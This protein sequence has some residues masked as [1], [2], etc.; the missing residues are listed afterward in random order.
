MPADDTVT[1]KMIF[2]HVFSLGSPLTF[3]KVAGS[4]FGARLSRN[5]FTYDNTG[6]YES[7]TPCTFLSLVQVGHLCQAV[8]TCSQTDLQSAAYMKF[9]QL[10]A[11]DLCRW[12]CLN[13][14]SRHTNFRDTFPPSSR[15]LMQFAANLRKSPSAVVNCIA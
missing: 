5:C 15:D 11:S 1:L 2:A 12:R 8:K 6:V 10:L 4:F 13:L 7:L 9:S 14:C 3:Q